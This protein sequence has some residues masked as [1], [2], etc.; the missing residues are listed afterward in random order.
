MYTDGLGNLVDHAGNPV[1]NGMALYLPLS[2]E[3]G[4]LDVLLWH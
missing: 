4:R 3:D 2:E 1:D